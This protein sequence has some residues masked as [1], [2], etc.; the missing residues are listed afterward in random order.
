MAVKSK[1]G[2]TVDKWRKKKYFPVMAPKIFQ[3]RELG[4]SLAFDPA[5]LEGRRMCVN[6]MVLT[7]NIKKQ[8]VNLTFVVDTVKGD[9]AYTTVRKYEISPASIKRKV[10]RQRDRLDESFQCVTQDNKMIR[11]KPLIITAVKTSNLVRAAL[12]R[13]SIQFIIN[14]IKRTDY[15]TLIM[16]VINDKLQREVAKHVKKIVPI[17]FVNI[18]K[19]EYLGEQKVADAAPVDEKKA[20]PVK[21]DAPVPAEELKEEPA[22]KTEA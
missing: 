1:K 7:G 20:E 6:L 21:V 5:S 17:R 9:T 18:R 14:T 22:P 16:D 4:K 19:L 11:I 15:D 2:K 3:E 13:S 12:R 8:E 10:R